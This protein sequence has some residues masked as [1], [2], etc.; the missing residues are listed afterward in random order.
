MTERSATE[1]R[2]AARVAALLACVRRCTPRRLAHAVQGHVARRIASFLPRFAPAE[3]RTNYVCAVAD[4]REV[5]GAR[6]VLTTNFGEEWTTDARVHTIWAFRPSGVTAVIFPAA[7]NGLLLRSAAESAGLPGG[8]PASFS[9]SNGDGSS[10]AVTAVFED[11]GCFQR[12]CHPGSYAVEFA[13]I[14]GLTPR[15]VSNGQLLDGSQNRRRV[16]FL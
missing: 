2:W 5:A 7:A 13:E 3:R 11:E 16:Q 12:A 14:E 10:W 1:L 6:H 4:W 8:Y 9:G 15:V